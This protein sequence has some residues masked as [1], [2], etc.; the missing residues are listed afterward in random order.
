MLQAAELLSQSTP[1]AFVSPPASVILLH[2]LFIKREFLL[3]KK[4]NHEVVGRQ[5]SGK[6]DFVAHY[7]NLHKCCCTQLSSFQGH[8]YRE[9]RLRGGTENV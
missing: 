6:A 1:Q 9:A 8:V 7:R 5:S 2:P 3:K 4:T